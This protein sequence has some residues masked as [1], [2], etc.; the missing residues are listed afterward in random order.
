MANDYIS[1][2]TLPNNETYDINDITK[3]PLEG[4]TLTGR[5]TTTKPINQIITGTGTIGSYTNSTYYPAKWTFNIGTEAPTNGDIIT[6][7]IPVAGHD[8]GVFLSINNGTNYHPIVLN[9]SGRLTTHYPVNTYI[10]LIFESTA[11]AGSMMALNGQTSSTRITVSGGAW[12]VINYYDSNSDYGYYQRMIYPNLKAGDGKIHP[13][14]IIMQLANGRFA[15]LTTTAPNN[16]GTTSISPK[17]T[18]KAANTNEFRLGPIYYMGANTTYSDGNNVGTYNVYAYYSGLIDCRYSFNLENTNGKRFTAYAPVYIV[19]TLSNGMIK[20][21][22]GEN[23]EW[24]TT[25]LPDSDNGKIYIYLG[26]AYDWYRITLQEN[27]PVYWYK[28]GAIREY[29]GASEYALAAPLSGISDAD[30]LKAIEGLTGTSG[31]LK[32]TAANTW[33]LDTSSYSITTGT[34]TSI[35]VQASSPLVSSSSA[36]SSSTL[37][38]TISFANQN[39]NTV[40]AGPSSGSSAAAPTFRALVSS[41]I[42]VT[43]TR[44]QLISTEQMA[45]TSWLPKYGSGTSIPA[46]TMALFADGLAIKSP[47]TSADAGWIRVTGTDETD[48]VLEIATSDDANKANSEKI[49]VRQYNSSSAQHEAILLGKIGDVYGATSF[50]VQVTA[51]KF[52]GALQGNASSATQFASAASVTL[53]GDVTG[54]AS[55]VKGWSVATTIANKAVTPAKMADTATITIGTQAIKVGGS[56]NTSTLVTDLG[57]S[58]AMHYRG[59]V[60]T[61]PTTTTPTGTYVS[62][63]VLSNSTNAKEFVYDGTNWRELGSESS[64]KK[65]QEAVSDPTAG[66]T[67]VTD[68]IATI[69]Q[70]TEGKITPTKRPLPVAAT[71]VAGITTVGASGGAAAYSHTH[72]YLANTNKGSKLKPIYITGNAAAEC[73]YMMPIYY[74]NFTDSTTAPGAYTATGT[75]LA[76][77][78]TGWY[79]SA[80]VLPGSTT[81]NARYQAQLYIA[82]QSG[83]ASPAHAYI[84]RMTDGSGFSD[85]STLLDDKNTYPADSN[86]NVISVTCG[87]TATLAT[88]NGTAVKINV[89]TPTYSDVG[90]AAESHE[91]DYIGKSR[92]IAYPSDGHYEGSGTVTGYAKIKIPKTKSSTM[93]SFDVDIYNYTAGTSV[94]YHIAGYNSSATWKRVTAYCIAPLSNEKA[95]LNVR[96]LSNGNDEMYVTI[97]ETNTSWYYPKVSVHNIVLGHSGNVLDDWKSGWTITFT[98]TE[99]DNSLVE[100]TVENTNIAY[101]SQAIKTGVAPYALT[102]NYL[103]VSSTTTAPTSTTPQIYEPKA[104]LGMWVNSADKGKFELVLG[105]ATATSSAGGQY[106]QLALYSAKTAGT[107]L[108]SA[109]GTSWTTATLQAKT[110]TIALTDD[111]TVTSVTATG[112]EP[113][114]LS[115]SISSKTVTISGSIAAATTS[116]AGIIKIGTEATDAAAGDHDHNSTYYALDGSNTGTKLRIST[117]SAA[118]TN[119]IQF[120]NSTTKK[121]SIGTDNNGVIGLYG[122]SKIVLRPQLDASTT[123]V[124]VTTAAMHPTGS[125]TLGTSSNKWS[126]IYGTTLYSGAITIGGSADAASKTISSNSTLYLNSA[127]STSIIFNKNGTE[128]ARFDTSSNFIPKSGLTNTIGTSATPWSAVYAT[129]FNGDLNGNAVSS[130]A[131]IATKTLTASD[132]ENTLTGTNQIKYYNHINTSRPANCPSDSYNS[133]LIVLGNSRGQHDTFQLEWS[134]NSK[135]LYM[136]G[137][138]GTPETIPAWNKII[139]SGNYTDYAVAKTAGVT[140]V[141][142]DATNK[143]LT[144]TINGTA[145]DVMTAAQM[146]T[147]LGLGTIATKADNAYMQFGGDDTGLGPSSPAATAKTYW[148]DATKVADNMITG[149]YN[150]SGTEYSL[151]FSKRSTY[152]SILKWGY[153]DKY[154]RILRI[155]GGSWKSD[156]WEKIDAGH[157]DTAGAANTLSNSYTS[158]SRIADANIAHVNNGGIVHFKATST[159]TA[160]KPASDGSILHFHWDYS[161]AAWDSQLHIP[162]HHEDSIQWR[163]HETTASW[164]SSWKTLLDNE[165]YSD[166]LTES[167][168]I[169]IIRL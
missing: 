3:L 98:N 57:L 19:G 29:S 65:V 78:T 155:Q 1:Q 100:T 96:F 11:S 89:T 166:F 45:F 37:N 72:N 52:I 30:D 99:F 4:G 136:R 69:S 163:A 74:T 40:L 152:G 146:S 149:Y 92:Y 49:V 61:D 68:F 106:G 125:M 43:L 143:K 123:G 67:A 76:T 24:W 145:A 158:S 135:Q 148:A 80:L 51:P 113:L 129:A 16:P 115:A 5:L 137:W 107:Y 10:T 54:N 161:G 42:P 53:T 154:L 12:R 169:E 50:P 153:G 44:A 82:S 122:A 140:A 91:H 150:H 28:N 165:N 86:G 26:D 114:T 41:D 85:W 167:Y 130:S 164:G 21:D 23:I 22:Y 6:I 118:Y 75:N 20:L 17:D 8:Y 13:Y 110:G 62:G 59:A 124:E 116:A 162:V 70:D 104:T 83:T 138:I 81:N 31:L 94:R 157:A 71:N 102:H 25:T 112:T 84:R 73:E 87:T 168:G 132:D 56:F 131:L 2:V 128:M 126:N 32:K 95:N 97:G 9:G 119:Q 103:F 88:I 46:K 156:D 111:I 90:A 127:A 63:D 142:W 101:Q 105:T 7:K 60:T 151:L 34:V 27:H 133:G 66:T 79:G 147:A 134:G 120:M 39:A 117:Q 48:T 15:S 47:A 139:H 160:N 33:T 144:R 109:D 38:T 93:F 159:M 14:S 141:T 121:G 35:Q 58:S 18:G 64:Y 108:K 77:N 55:S 36:A